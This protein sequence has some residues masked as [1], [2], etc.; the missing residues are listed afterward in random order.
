MTLL[1]IN[2]SS[3]VLPAG[4]VAGSALT[5]SAAAAPTVNSFSTFPASVASVTSFGLTMA[6]PHNNAGPWATLQYQQPLFTTTVSQPTIRQSTPPV[7]GA[8]NN[9]VC[10]IK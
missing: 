5:A 4:P 3:S 6:Q 2:D 10:L 1:R 9:Q 8:L 7:G